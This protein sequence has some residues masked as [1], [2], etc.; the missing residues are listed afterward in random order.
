M[1]SRGQQISV[2]LFVIIAAALLIFIVFAIS[3]AFAGSDIVYHAKFANAAGIGPGSSVHYIGGTKIGHVTKLKIDPQDPSL[4]DV[5]FTVD[6]GLPIKTD[7]MVG[8]QSF[9]PLGENHIE[10]KAGSQKAPL[11]PSGATLPSKAY[12]GFNDLADQLNQLSPKAQELISNLNDRVIQLRTTLDRVNDL[13]NDKNRANISASLDQL[14]GILKENRPQIQ[15]T[16]KNVNAASAKMEPLIDE[17]RKTTQ[18][19]SE[20]L[21]HVDSIVADNKDDIKAAI[22]QLRTALVS[23][24]ELAD[25]LNGTLDANQDNIDQILLNLREVSENLR[26]FTDDIKTRPSSLI[27]SRTPRDRKPGEKQ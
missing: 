6:R 5:M 3:G 24:N 7:S 20:T 1:D 10:I 21:K 27:L 25:K 26:E 8:I 23:V 17:L 2:G 13:V 14:Q 22:Q 15:S 11:A 12:F 16:L 18:Q 9:S 4:L 19:A